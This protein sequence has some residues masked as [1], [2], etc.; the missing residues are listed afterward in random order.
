MPSLLAWEKKILQ[1]KTYRARDCLRRFELLSHTSYLRDM[2]IVSINPWLVGAQRYPLSMCKILLG[3]C[4]HSTNEIVE[5]WN[6]ERTVFQHHWTVPSDLV[7]KPA[8]QNFPRGFKRLP[9]RVCDPSRA[10][11]T[12]TPVRPSAPPWQSAAAWLRR[13]VAV[14]T[15]NTEGRASAGGGREGKPNRQEQRSD[16][17][18]Q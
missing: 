8:I 10:A 14:A 9:L 17:T 15:A 6:S 13:T 5:T 12:V 2:N 3:Q 7:E 11:A 4:F 16:V 1:V 18:E